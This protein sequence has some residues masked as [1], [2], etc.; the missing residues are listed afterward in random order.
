[1]IKCTA[2]FLDETVSPHESIET[3]HDEYVITFL[4]KLGKTSTAVYY[5]LTNSAGETIDIKA[6]PEIELT[7]HPKDRLIIG[8]P[9][10]EV[11]YFMNPL[12]NE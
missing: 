2:Y 1:M 12:N 9:K 8:I 6:P 11:D 3:T 4:P 10:K 5:S 7:V